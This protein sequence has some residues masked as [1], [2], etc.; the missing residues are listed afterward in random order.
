LGA[1]EW[2]P[3]GDSALVGAVNRKTWMESILDPEIDDAIWKIYTE[4][5]MAMLILMLEC[6]KLAISCR[7]DVYVDD[8]KRWESQDREV[9]E[10]LE[11]T[12]LIETR[13][14]EKL[15]KLRADCRN[16]RV[17]S[18]LFHACV[19]TAHVG[20]YRYRVRRP[21]GLGYCDRHMG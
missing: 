17:E 3:N 8:E 10:R 7:R 14:D 6:R 11:Q 9:D 18:E 5:V 12:M 19:K 4:I 15:T 13:P 2:R 1:P 16:K 20:K 21:T